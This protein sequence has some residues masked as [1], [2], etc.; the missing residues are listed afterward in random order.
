MLSHGGIEMVAV[1]AGETENPK[2]SNFSVQSP[3]AYTHKA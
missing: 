3:Q 1:A 2:V